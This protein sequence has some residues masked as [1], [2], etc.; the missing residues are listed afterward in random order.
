MRPH[1]FTKG[2][3]KT[4]LPSA[5]TTSVGLTDFRTTLESRTNASPSATDSKPRFDWKN[6]FLTVPIEKPAYSRRKSS[7]TTRRNSS[8]SA[9]GAAGVA[10]VVLAFGVVEA[11]SVAGV[12][13][14]VSPVPDVAGVV[15]GGVTGVVVAGLV[16]G[17]TA[18]GLLV[19]ATGVVTALVFEVVLFVATG[20]LGVVTVGWVVFVGVAFGLEGVG[21][22]VAEGVVGFDVAGGVVGVVG[23]VGRVV[24]AGSILKIGGSDTAGR[25]VAVGLGV[26]VT[27]L[28]LVPAGLVEA[29]VDGGVLTAGLP[30]GA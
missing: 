19:G 28:G 9:E 6:A 13:G 29:V 14:V 30:I 25:V 12:T 10:G 2:R 24:G 5:K 8:N 11:G 4:S 16:F 15:D 7:W 1:R 18:G 21:F 20:V 23:V 22:V 26:W 3:V 27:P 17:A